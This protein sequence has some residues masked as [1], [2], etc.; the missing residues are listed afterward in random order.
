MEE[1]IDYGELRPVPTPKKLRRANLACR[2]DLMITN[3]HLSQYFD[4]FILVIV[5]NTGQ[6][7]PVG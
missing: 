1:T 4:I 6:L 3:M 7:D 5:M 2:F